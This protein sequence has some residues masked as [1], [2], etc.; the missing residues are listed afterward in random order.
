MHLIPFQNK[1]QVNL[2]IQHG[3][4]Y[5][6]YSKKK[7]NSRA[8]STPGTERQRRHGTSSN[9]QVTNQQTTRHFGTNVSFHWQHAVQMSDSIIRMM[10]L[11]DTDNLLILANDY[12]IR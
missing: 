11:D 5:Y 10:T 7:Q 8:N 2:N 9:L 4:G 12:D 6:Y 3:N 1:L